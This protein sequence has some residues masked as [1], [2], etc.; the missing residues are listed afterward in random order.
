MCA[1]SV[2]AVDYLLFRGAYLSAVYVAVYRTVAHTHLALIGLPVEQSCRGCLVYYAGR[3][4]KPFEKLYYL[5]RREVGYGVK[6]ARAFV[7]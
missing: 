5:G 4:G 2:E 6:V 1:V 3:C 7:K